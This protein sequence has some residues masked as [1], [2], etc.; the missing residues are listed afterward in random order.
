[1]QGI[2]GGEHKE[3]GCWGGLRAY[4]KLMKCMSRLS[5]DD[6][7]AVASPRGQPEARLLAVARGFT[8]ILNASPAADF[9]NISIFVSQGV[10][11][12]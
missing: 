12:N 9:R 3:I 11:L 6:P 5:V 1:M 10:E 8:P 4:S 7:A 2:H